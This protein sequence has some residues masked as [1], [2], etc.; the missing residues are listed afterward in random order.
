MFGKVET[1][2]CDCPATAGRTPRLFVVSP[3][4][5]VTQF[6][7]KTISGLLVV[8]GS[9]YEKNGKWSGSTYRFRL[10]SGAVAVMAL[11]AMHQAPLA[12]FATWGELHAAFETAAA[13]PVNA[14]SLEAAIR[15]AWPP[16]EPG[17]WRGPGVVA[18]L[19]QRQAELAALD[20]RP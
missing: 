6:A 1:R 19:D 13:R 17:S 15:A 20:A 18:E 8:T 7:G 14:A 10:A 5:E 4:G 12:Q 3:K 9:D 2:Y 11:T 16:R